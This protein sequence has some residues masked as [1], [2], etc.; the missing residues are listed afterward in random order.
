MRLSKE[1]LGGRERQAAL[2]VNQVGQENNFI[3]ILLEGDPSAGCNLDCIGARVYVTVVEVTQMREIQGGMGH[4]GHQNP[5]EAHFGLAA[6]EIVD[7]IEIHWP[8]KTHTVSEFEGI[9]ANQILEIKYNG[10]MKA[11]EF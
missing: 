8:D 4:S 10:E 1:H 9:N 11:I 2:F 5:K 6:N 3:H 7:K